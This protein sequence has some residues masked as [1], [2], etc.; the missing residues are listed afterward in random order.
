MF[1][2]KLK[3]TFKYHVLHAFETKREYNSLVIMGSDEYSNLEP[4]DR[5]F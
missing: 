2:G 1:C 3:S 5:S 4:S